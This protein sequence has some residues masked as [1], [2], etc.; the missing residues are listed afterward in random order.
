MHEW[1]LS[2]KDKT[3]LQVCSIDIVNNTINYDYKQQVVPIKISERGLV[4]LHKGTLSRLS[5]KSE[6]YYL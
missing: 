6:K 5:E 2:V 1:L 3:E 4:M